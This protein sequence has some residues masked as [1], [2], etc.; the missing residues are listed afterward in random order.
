MQE[1]E[2]QRMQQHQQ[3]DAQPSSGWVE[4]FRA[5][6]D[7]V[8][9]A[10]AGP[11]DGASWAS[12]F[13]RQTAGEG[14]VV[15]SGCWFAHHFP[16]SA[17]AFNQVDGR[18]ATRASLAACRETMFTGRDHPALSWL[19]VMISPRGRQQLPRVVALTPASCSAGSAVTPSKVNAARGPSHDDPLEDPAAPTWVDGFNRSLGQPTVNAAEGAL[20]LPV[21]RI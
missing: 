2:Q 11:M 14:Q 15:V 20:G 17:L 16:K 9:D 18:G 21:R 13:A 8:A 10:P 3:H 6:A 19:P 7:S 1:A 5:T 12:E 4:E